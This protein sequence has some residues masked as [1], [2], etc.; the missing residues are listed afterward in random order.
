MAKASGGALAARV[1]KTHGIDHLFG[2][3]G[4]HVY[5]IFEACEAEGIRVIDVRHEESGAHMAEGFAL[6]TGRPAACIGT[7]GPGFTNMLTGVANAYAGSSPLLAIGGRAT[8]QQFDTRALQDFNQ[9]DIVKPMT[10]YAR[11]IF[12]TRR[13]PEYFDTAIHHAIHIDQITTHNVPPTKQHNVM[14]P[15]GGRYEALTRSTGSSNSTKDATTP[16]TLGGRCS[17][18][19][20]N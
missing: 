16:R 7:A 12:E 17:L 2:I 15:I 4:G 9:I 20:C 18:P 14:D 13:I 6:T 10:K 8:L 11:S 3:I 1:M 19:T 5:P